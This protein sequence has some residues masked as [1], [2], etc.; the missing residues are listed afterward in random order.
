MHCLHCGAIM[1]YETFYEEDQKLSTWK[2]ILCGEYMDD[3]ILRNRLSLRLKRTKGRTA[4]RIPVFSKPPLAKR[5][6]KNKI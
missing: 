5:N 3:V 4:E 1:F 2:C 6:T